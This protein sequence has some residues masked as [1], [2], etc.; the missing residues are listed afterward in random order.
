MLRTKRSIDKDTVKRQR[1]LAEC[2]E[3]IGDV[4][5]HAT[6]QAK[7]K[8]VLGGLKQLESLL[9]KLLA[10]RTKDPSKF[11]GVFW[12]RAFLEMNWERP[13]NAYFLLRFNPE[14]HL[15]SLGSVLGLLTRTHETAIG[16]K[17]GVLS[18]ICG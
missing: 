7:N 10:L 2:L 5:V 18:T 12:S 6:K 9:E 1:R 16:S 15:L 11:D 8:T 3:G 17:N 14:E 13:E 4:L